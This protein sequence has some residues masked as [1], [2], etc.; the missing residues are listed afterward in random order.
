MWPSPESTDKLLD[1]VRTD[2]GGAVDRLFGEFREPLRRMIG[3]LSK[4]DRV[5]IGLDLVPIA[6]S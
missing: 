4:E 2:Q 6:D 5:L 1:D 3:D